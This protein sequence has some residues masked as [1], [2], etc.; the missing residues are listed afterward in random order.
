MFL[1]TSGANGG[2]TARHRKAET[3]AFIPGTGWTF[4]GH[5]DLGS[6]M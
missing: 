1:K 6:R 2:I 3:K 5:E 4:H